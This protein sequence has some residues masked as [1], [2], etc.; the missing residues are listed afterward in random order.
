MPNELEPLDPM[1]TEAISELRDRAPANDLWPGIT[2]RLMA[3]RPKG[4][5]LLRWPT[6]MAAGIAIALFSAAGTLLVMRRD[7]AV[8]PS[9]PAAFTSVAFTAADSTIELAI[10]DLER[11]VRATMTQLDDPT[12]LGIVRG[13]TA[14]DNAIATAAA[15]R[16]ATPGDSRAEH[17][18]TSSLRTKL[19]VLRSVSALTARQS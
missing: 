6:A 4:S 8:S 1:L 18:L 3:R 7:G 16:L 19:D 11:S 9:E 5:L 10:R 14:L 15:Q 17:D 12:R 2:P 13:L